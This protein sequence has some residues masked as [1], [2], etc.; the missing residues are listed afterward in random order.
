M[1]INIIGMGAGN[2]LA[3]TTGI[4]WGVTRVTH[5]LPVD[6]VFDMHD[7]DIISKDRIKKA[8]ETGTHMF[9]IGNYPIDKIVKRFGT[10]FFSDSVCYAIAYAVYIGAKKINLYG[11]NQARENNKEY[12]QHKPG[13]DYWLGFARGMGIEVNVYGQKSEVGK[14]FDHKAYGYG[15][16]QDEMVM[17]HVGNK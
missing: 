9:H 10:A 4:R 8:A 11:I 6:I 2:E 7:P 14:T 17:G 13:T 3:P 16:Y 15:I 12:F 5:D 1:E